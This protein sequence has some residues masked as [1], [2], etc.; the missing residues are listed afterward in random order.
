MEPDLDGRHRSLSFVISTRGSTFER[1]DAGEVPSQ[2]LTLLQDNLANIT[3]ISLSLHG[4]HLSPIE[5]KRLEDS[6][7]EHYDKAA[8]PYWC[9]VLQAA[10]NPKSLEIIDLSSASVGISSLLDHVIRKCTWPYLTELSI[11]RTSNIKLLPL[12]PWNS[13]YSMGWYLFLQK[14]LDK[15]ILRHGT[16]LQCLKLHNIVGLEQTATPPAY[17]LQY[18]GP[19]YP[20]DP[21]PSLSALR[22]SVALWKQELSKLEKIDVTVK[23]K[24]NHPCG[25][26]SPLDAWLRRSDIQALATTMGVEAQWTDTVE[27]QSKCSQVAFDL[28]NPTSN[29]LGSIGN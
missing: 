8:G 28:A 20:D 2:Q 23:A 17:S 19:E 26:I 11:V 10:R 15:F 4:V 14:D 22:N 7:Y 18:I 16:T 12:E 29:I 25:A 24:A 5:S 6:G 3:R 1:R 13:D 27:G 9:N 21:T